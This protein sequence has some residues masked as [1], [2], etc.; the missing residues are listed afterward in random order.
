M[1]KEKCTAPEL[2]EKFE[3]FQEN[4]KPGYA[5][6]SHVNIGFYCQWQGKWSGFDCSIFCGKKHGCDIKL[7]K[8]RLNG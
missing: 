8:K 3:V 6:K 7:R 2:A 4:D 1:Q 5:D